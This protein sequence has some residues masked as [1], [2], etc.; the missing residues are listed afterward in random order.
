MQNKASIFARFL[1]AFALILIQQ[2]A[3]AQTEMRW[4]T[5]G[6]GFTVPSNF[7]VSANNAEEYTAENDNLVLSI[8]PIQDENLTK[9]NMAE[10]VLAMAEEMKYDAV[11]EG[12]EVNIHD[13]TGYFIKGRKD[14]VNAVVMALLDKESSTNLVVVIVYAEESFDDAVAIINSF[15]AYD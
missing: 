3:F 15:V 10:V 2:A 13:F 6:V 11:D 4:D 14:G 12:E 1:T 7:K 5:H 8:A 9:E